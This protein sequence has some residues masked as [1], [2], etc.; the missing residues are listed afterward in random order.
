VQLREA[1]MHRYSE[2]YE[3]GE[4]QV[5]ECIDCGYKH[6]FPLP[7]EEE[8]DEFYKS[9]FEES[10]P[11]P[12]FE[13]KKETIAEHVGGSRNKRILDVGAW[14]GDFLD[15]F[16]PSEWKRVG[17]EPNEKKKQVLE[18]KGI[19]VHQ[20][21]I[22]R[23]NTSDLG[24]FDAVNL[25]FVLEHVL[26][27]RQILQNIFD[28]LLKPSGIICVELPNDFNPLQ[29]CA[30]K[31]LGV[32]LYWLTTPCLH[33]NY[34]SSESLEK[35]LTSVGYEVLLREADFP[36]EF[37]LLAGENYLRNEKVGRSIHKKR[38]D[39]E[40]NLK[41]SGQNNL[42]RELYRHLASLNIGRSI[43]MF[44]EKPRV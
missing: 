12:N 8:L 36:M 24:V 26:H 22:D 14:N 32:P 13:D 1:K 40:E 3:C 9:H 39:F 42:K 27:P 43:M 29:M 21:L 11:S 2:I 44:A 10:T 30:V 15:L 33:V 37:F 31:S 20:D 4:I 18:A 25:S 19:E 7:K 6:Q 35:L 41:K 16:E 34:F 17:I 5:I 23:I 38:C 28:N